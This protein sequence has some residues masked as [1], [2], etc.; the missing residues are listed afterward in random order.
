[1]TMRRNT[2]SGVLAGIGLIAFID[3]TVFHQLLHW[4]HFY[5]KSTA[6][7]G[8]VSDGLF[9]ALGFFAIVAGLFLFA[10]LRRRG[11]S[12]LARWI[13]GLLLGAGGFQLYD[14]LVQHKLMGLHQ[15]RYHVDLIPYDVT[16]NVVAAIMIIVGVVLTVRTRSGRA[17]APCVS[18]MSA[19][20]RTSSTSPARCSRFSGSRL[21][22]AG[23]SDPA[24]SLAAAPQL[25]LGSP[26]AG[27]GCRGGQRT[28]GRGRRH[29]LSSPTWPRICCSACLL[30]CCW[31]WRRRSPCCCVHCPWPRP[32]GSAAC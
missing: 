29:Q 20:V 26:A 16:W 17:A 5:D 2:T 3:E 7:V 18:I 27:R 6:E 28:A 22:V 32:G 8:L 24:G 10:D 4:H 19:A 12:A 1:M 23:H 15:I 14:G 31:S 13:G 9:H 21:P 30:R 25:V 11:S